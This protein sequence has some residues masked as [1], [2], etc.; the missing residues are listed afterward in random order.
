MRN[1]SNLPKNL[2]G[3]HERKITFICHSISKKY[4]LKTNRNMFKSKKNINLN[5]GEALQLIK[6]VRVFI[7][8][9]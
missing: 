7:S 1:G 3:P 5:V 4:C 2:S 6:K 9:F 8:L